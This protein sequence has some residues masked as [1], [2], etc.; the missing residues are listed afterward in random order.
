MNLPHTG[1]HQITHPH[2]EASRSTYIQHPARKPSK[3]TVSFCSSSAGLHLAGLGRNEKGTWVHLLFPRPRYHKWLP[4]A[5]KQQQEDRTQ[6]GSIVTYGSQDTAIFL[7]FSEHVL[8]WVDF[9]KHGTICA[10][11]LSPTID[12]TA[13]LMFVGCLNVEGS[14]EAYS[15]YRIQ[16][17]GEPPSGRCQLL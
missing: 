14:L 7:L 15:L 5:G 11:S 2:S 12:T 8:F 16:C 10:F 17:D 1:N 3:L 4:T 9:R 13:Y 6:E